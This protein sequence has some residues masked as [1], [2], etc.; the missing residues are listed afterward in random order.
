MVL[1]DPQIKS[2]RQEGFLLVENVLEDADFAPVIDE[3]EKWVDARAVV[4]QN[5]EIIQDLYEGDGFETRYGKLFAQSREIGEGMDIMLSRG[6]RMFEFLRNEN[7]LDVIEGILGPEILCSPIQH[8]RA[9]TPFPKGENGYDLFGNV[10]WHQDAGV[11]QE[12]ADPF[13]ILTVWIPLV[14]AT[15]EMGCMEILPGVH[16]QGLLRHQDIG[17]TTIVPELLPKVDPVPMPCK[18]GSFI[19]MDKYTPHRG[20]DNVTDRVRWTIDLRFQKNGTKTGR[21]WHPDF[22][23]RSRS[24]P[25]SVLCDHTRWCAMWE[26]GLKKG[27]GEKMHRV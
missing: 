17:G 22:P 25:D 24:N 18:K 12:E 14:D 8:L 23:V 19:I 4:L 20:L 16:K 3:I 11:T 7:L 26:A 15:V 1:S 6:E 13:E 21:H 9:K 5:D 27:E 10:P 2:F